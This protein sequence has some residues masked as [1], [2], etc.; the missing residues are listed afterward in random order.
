MLANLEANRSIGPAAAMVTCLVSIH[1]ACFINGTLY[2]WIQVINM[3]N[4]AITSKY[5][6]AFEILR[7][8]NYFAYILMA[9]ETHSWYNKFGK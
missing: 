5:H 4:R 2:S 9:R 1:R 8:G 7:R 6:I 3:G